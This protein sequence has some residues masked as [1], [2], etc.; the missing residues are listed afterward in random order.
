[1][2]G[3][4]QSR[5]DVDFE[6]ELVL[7][8]EAPASLSTAVVAAR[9]SVVELLSSGRRDSRDDVLSSV[10]LLEVR[11]SCVCDDFFLK[12]RSRNPGVFVF[13]FFPIVKDIPLLRYALYVTHVVFLLPVLTNSGLKVEDSAAFVLLTGISRNWRSVTLHIT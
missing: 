12:S 6:E 10:D 3:W 1:M 2:E 8:F 11:L 7:D 9:S 13:S 4:R 5:H